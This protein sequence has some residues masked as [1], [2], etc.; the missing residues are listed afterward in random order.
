MSNTKKNMS[1]KISEEEILKLDLLASKKNVSRSEIVRDILSNSN[2]LKSDKIEEKLIEFEE[3]TEKNINKNSENIE[4]IISKLY[5]VAIRFSVSTF[6]QLIN[7]HRHA[8][9][10]SN[11]EYQMEVNFMFKD[12]ETYA[13]FLLSKITYEFDNKGKAFEKS[14]DYK[15]RY[16]KFFE[17]VV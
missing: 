17:S 16:E 5:Y 1:I 11:D 4:N 2:D 10:R 14:E 15:K 9:N 8:D 3:N 7:L 13:N 12:P 6:C